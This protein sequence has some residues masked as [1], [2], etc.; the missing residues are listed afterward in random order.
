MSSHTHTH[1]IVHVQVARDAFEAGALAGAVEALN[2][3]AAQAAAA[4]V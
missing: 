1:T 4:K 2:G 3:V